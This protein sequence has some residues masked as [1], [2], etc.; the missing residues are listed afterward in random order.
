MSSIDQ[1]AFGLPDRAP[2]PKLSHS[3]YIKRRLGVLAAA[4]ALPVLGASAYLMNRAAND[5]IGGTDVPATHV[6]NSDKFTTRVAQPGDTEAGIASEYTPNRHNV[7]NNIDNLDK[8]V[9]ELGH[10]QLIVGDNL[11]VPITTV[12]PN[13][14]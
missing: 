4:L 5:R 1:P 6:L 2:K 8:Q 9:K 7:E 11:S 13:K 3:T 14:R 10:N 12:P